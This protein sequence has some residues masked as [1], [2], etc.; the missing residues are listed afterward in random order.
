MGRE[1]EK[2]V[3]EA[4]SKIKVCLGG[5]RCLGPDRFLGLLE[6]VFFIFIHTCLTVASP[7]TVIFF[8]IR[9][10]ISFF[11]KGGFSQVLPCMKALENV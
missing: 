2:N 8:L 7:F 11:L 4:N 10:S 9:K 1:G 6:V 3:E 5:D